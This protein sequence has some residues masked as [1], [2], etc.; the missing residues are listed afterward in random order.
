MKQV[1]TVKRSSREL[2]LFFTGW[3]M[4]AALFAG[5]NPYDTDVC[6]CYDYRSE[7][8]DRSL[9]ADYT[10]IRVAAWSMGVRMASGVLK[11]SGLPVTEKHA[12]NGTLYPVDD[13]RGIPAGLLTATIENLNE[14]SIQKFYRRMCGPRLREFLNSSPTRPVEELKEELIRIVGRCSEESVPDNSWDRV[15]IGRNDLIFPYANQLAAWHSHPQVVITDD[16][17][18]PDFKTLFYGTRR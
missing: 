14:R 10:A 18:Y 6:I 5:F 16:Y 11:N 3:G 15:V 4:D 17:H 1:F 9:Y 7:E 8:W 12:V 13:T 2:F